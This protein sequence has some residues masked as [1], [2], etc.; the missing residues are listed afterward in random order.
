M[1]YARSLYPLFLML[2]LLQV[3]CGDD[4]TDPYARWQSR[5]HPEGYFR[6]FFLG[7]PW[8]VTEESVPEHLVLQLEPLDY[9][10]LEGPPARIAAEAFWVEATGE[11]DV[12]ENRAELW[13]DAGCEVGDISPHENAFFQQGL[14]FEADHC[15]EW[16]QE[17]FF[18]VAGGT[19]VFSM[20]GRD[21]S[22]SADVE[23]MIDGFGPAREVKQ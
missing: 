21:W 13:R 23:T 15:Q 17:V 10:P 18:S 5:S 16:V 20:R 2:I 19:A 1:T 14:R 9:A 11:T 12:A 22:L 6:V 7:P 8:R 3:G 4:G